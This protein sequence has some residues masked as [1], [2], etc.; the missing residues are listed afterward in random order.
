MG[1]EGALTSLDPDV[2]NI[3]AQPEPVVQSFNEKKGVNLFNF[4]V[5]Y[6]KY[7]LFNISK[8]LRNPSGGKY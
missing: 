5:S 6:C 4:L 2:V 1:T 8:G 3:W 7:V